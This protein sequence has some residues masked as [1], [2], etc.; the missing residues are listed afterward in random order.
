MSPT[1]IAGYRKDTSK[2]P[3][4]LNHYN[5]KGKGKRE[6]EITDGY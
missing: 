1:R 4:I 2:W 3:K 6:R 5:T